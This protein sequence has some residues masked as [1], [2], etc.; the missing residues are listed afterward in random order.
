MVS[1]LN[2]ELS[3]R[4]TIEFSRVAP[5]KI[6]W[7]SIEVLQLTQ[8]GTRCKTRLRGARGIGGKTRRHRDN[9]LSAFPRG[10]PASVH[11]SSG[12]ARPSPPFSS[13][14][15]EKG[16]PSISVLEF[17]RRLHRQLNRILRGRWE[18]EELYFL[19]GDEI[20]WINR[21]IRRRRLRRRRKGVT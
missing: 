21:R 9:T 6:H 20:P 12:T 14:L 19:A 7:I 10:K 13:G 8:K 17:R 11:S 15:R 16:F 2:A 4:A 3:P 18:L 5:Y 1:Q